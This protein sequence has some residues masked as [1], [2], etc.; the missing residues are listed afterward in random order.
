MKNWKEVT[1]FES[2]LDSVYNRN[3]GNYIFE[4]DCVSDLLQATDHCH[5]KAPG[6][7]KERPTFT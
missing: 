7:S 2:F 5:S 6:V 3:W 4:H 1:H